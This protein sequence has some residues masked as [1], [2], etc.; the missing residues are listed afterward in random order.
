M[1]AAI[2]AGVYV[3]TM[4]LFLLILVDCLWMRFLQRS[5]R[6]FLP[7]KKLQTIK[8][9][10]FEEMKKIYEAHEINLKIKASAVIEARLAQGREIYWYFPIN[11]M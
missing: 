9:E 6:Y 5:V 2:L 8:R 4:V 11:I 7:R 3:A 1:T 10:R